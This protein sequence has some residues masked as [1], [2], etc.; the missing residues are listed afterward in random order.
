MGKTIGIDLGTSKTCVA[1]FEGGRAKIINNQE[2][3]PTTPSVVAFSDS[4][5]WLVGLEAKRQAITNP[6]H[7][8]TGI[9]R[10]LG[11]KFSDRVVRRAIEYSPFKIVA[12]KDDDAVVEI[13]GR[14]HS[15]TEITA[16]ILTKMKQAAEAYLGEPVTAA[17]I[18]MSSF[19]YFQHQ[20]IQEACHL[21]GLNFCRVINGSVSASITYGFFQKEKRIAV[22]DL[23][24][25]AFNVAIV[26]CDDGAFEVIA[27][28][29]DPLLGGDDFDMRI[30]NW[31]GDEFQREQGIDLRQDKQAWRRLLEEAEKAKMRLSTLMETE[32]NLPYIAADP[33]GPIHL[34][35]MLSRAKM[36][37]M[38]VDMI[39]RAV[40]PCQTA[41]LEAGMYAADIDRV[42]LVGGMCRVPLVQEK[43][44]EIF[45][46]AGFKGGNPD[47]IVALGAAIQGGVLRGDIKDV[48]LFDVIQFAICVETSTGIC[49]KLIHKN[50]T[51][52]TKKSQIFS[53]TNYSTC[54][55][56]IF[57]DGPEVGVDQKAIGYFEIA[58]I[59]QTPKGPPQ[60]ELTVDI[61]A[62]NTLHIEARELGA[63]RQLLLKPIALSASCLL[64]EVEADRLMMTAMKNIG[65][66]DFREADLI[67]NEIDALGIELSEDFHFLKASYFAGINDTA[68]ARHHLA[69][70]LNR[71]GRRGVYYK[72]ALSLF[73]QMM[74]KEG[75]M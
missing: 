29:G 75:K 34:N 27:T 49:T 9:M 53:V 24:G 55:I 65:Q 16:R 15:P 11:R 36:E 14:L 59:S 63:D 43:V 74:A 62:N 4:G 68:M 61:D 22:F 64:P 26:R 67:I 48:M 60:I 28:A 17:V 33:S 13:G 73:N 57:E 8:V 2:G 50:T 30:A 7:T 70:Y 32:I 69:A 10:L 71:A 46:V 58:G 21:A 37:E 3:Y 51:F 41:L 45:G 20:A 5:E 23:G 42:V 40:A 52:P 38:V 56:R 66:G 25:G 19:G 12:G 1:V 18:T 31:L 54:R 6:Q 47:E 44:K 72:N 35:L 39:E